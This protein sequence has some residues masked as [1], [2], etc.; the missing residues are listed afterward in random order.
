M[1]VIKIGYDGVD[2]ILPSKI[3]VHSQGSLYAAFD[4]RVFC[5]R[6]NFSE[7]LNY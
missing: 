5:K 1:N 2:C 3:K 4:P 6:V 7:E